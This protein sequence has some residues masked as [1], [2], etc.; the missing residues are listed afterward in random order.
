VAESEPESA[1]VL[2]A[3]DAQFV[4]SRAWS[5]PA[6]IA[7]GEIGRL[8]TMVY[9]DTTSF[10]PNLGQA[11]SALLYISFSVVAEYTD[12]A[13]RQRERMTIVA[14]ARHLP[15]GAHEYAQ[16][17]P[18][19]EQISGF[20]MLRRSLRTAGEKAWRWVQSSSREDWNRISMPGIPNLR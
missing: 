18:R 2:E 3:T 4:T 16:L 20:D 8:M 7:S 1:G 13:G 14:Q 15:H 17:P 10:P 11:Q 5:I 12:L 19:Y 6:T 9:Q